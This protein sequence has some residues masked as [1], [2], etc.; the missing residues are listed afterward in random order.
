MRYLLLLPLFFAALV[1]NAAEPLAIDRVNFNSLKDDW[2]QVEIKLSCNDSIPTSKNDRYLDDIKV[3]VYLTY[4][5]DGQ[6]GAFS[7]YK[8][9]VEIITMEKGDTNNVYF[10]LPGLVVERDRF[11]TAP[12]FFYVELSIGDQALPPQKNGMSSNLNETS[13]QSMLSKAEAESDANKGIL[14]PIY[15]MTNAPLGRVDRL[16]TFLRRDYRSE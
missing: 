14:M 12:D 2:I 1:L 7:F 13:L 5:E 15:L 3:T 16:P 8:S 11:K 9:D 10:Y 6:K 4:S